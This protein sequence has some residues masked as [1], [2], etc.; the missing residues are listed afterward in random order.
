MVCLFKPQ[1]IHA[2]TVQYSG[3]VSAFQAN[4]VRLDPSWIKSR[5]E[6]NTS[7]LLTLDPDRLLHN[8][9]INAGLPSQVK[10][11]G[12]WEAPDIGLRGHF[13]GH[14]FRQFHFW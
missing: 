11:L 6:L 12:G 10:P 7:Y 5:E 1:H 2:Q 8:F 9:K 14:Y 4:D 3:G 13:T